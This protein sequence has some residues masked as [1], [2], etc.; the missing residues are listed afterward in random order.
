[1]L[2]ETKITRGPRGPYLPRERVPPDRRMADLSDREL[3]VYDAIVEFKALND[4]NSPSTRDLCQA[5]RIASTSLI[6]RYLKG[7]AEHGYIWLGTS[8]D[9]RS[10]RVRGGHW[11][12]NG[13]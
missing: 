6:R 3:A 11:S 12:L 8:G 4:G 5:T 9:A 2:N 13:G 10:I 1:M 7:I